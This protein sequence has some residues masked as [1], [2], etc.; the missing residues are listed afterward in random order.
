MGL[1]I[2]INYSVKIECSE[3]FITNLLVNMNKV[4]LSFKSIGS[5]NN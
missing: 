1:L 4:R 2:H 5:I 3:S